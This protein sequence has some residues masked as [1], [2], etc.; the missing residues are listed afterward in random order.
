MSDIGAHDAINAIH[1]LKARYFR[2]MDTKQWDLW[3]QL[4]TDDMVFYHDD[5]TSSGATAPRTRGA[6]RFVEHVSSLL[7]T[8]VTVHHG[9]MPEIT[10]TGDRTATGIWTM[11]DVISD[12]ERSWAF[13]GY[14]HYHERYERGPDDEWRIRELRLTRLAGS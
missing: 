6:D 4:F 9:H 13:R 3:R 14:G 1:I 8:A 2:Y 5:S 12:P 11:S 7:A 10:I